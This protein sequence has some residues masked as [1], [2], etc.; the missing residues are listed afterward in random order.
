MRNFYLALAALIMAA[1]SNGSSDPNTA[2]QMFIYSALSDEGAELVAGVVELHVSGEN[3]VSG[4]WEMD[5][6]DG[7][8][9]DSEIGP[10]V[11]EGQLS[12]M[13]EGN[14]L[15]LNLNPEMADNNVRLRGEWSGRTISG[16]WTW[17]G[18]PGALANGTFTLRAWPTR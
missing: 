14:T 10:Q 12:G 17:V 11:G 1:C 4:E 15:S 9:T 2:Q 18:F 3:V 5:W 6:V 8:D 16:T 7:A 13:L